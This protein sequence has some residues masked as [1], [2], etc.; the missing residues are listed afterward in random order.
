MERSN[1]FQTPFRRHGVSQTAE[2]GNSRNAS[3]SELHAKEPVFV[4]TKTT[5]AALV[6]SALIAGSAQAS[7]TV[8]GTTFDDTSAVAGQNLV[9]NGAG[10]RKKLFFRVYTAGLYLPAK[11]QTAEAVL[12]QTG[13]VRVRL[14]LMRNVSAKSFVDALK[15]GLKDNTPEKELATINAE[16]TRLIAVKTG[17]AVDFS[18]DGKDTSVTLN[19]NLVGN[20]IG[21]R[22]LFNAVLRIWIGADAID[23]TL[24]AGLLGQK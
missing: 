1:H 19:G 11:A 17:D 3:K 16:V 8:E 20:G 15:D 22:A 2:A 24:K 21:G 14:I 18:F 7:V 12:S 5:L 13:A 4:M 10:F 9:L 6:C 23:D